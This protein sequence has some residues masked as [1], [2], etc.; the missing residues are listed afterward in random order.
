[1]PEPGFMLI[2]IL[3]FQLFGIYAASNSPDNN[4]MEE[5]QPPNCSVQL[6][7]LA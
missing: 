7:D 5:T 6:F 1:M 3:T 2:N 4:L